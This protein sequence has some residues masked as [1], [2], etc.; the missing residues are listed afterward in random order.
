[1]SQKK[2]A[3]LAASFIFVVMFVLAGSP[4]STHAQGVTATLSGRILDASGGSVAKAA[5]T[6]VNTATGFTRTV[7]SSDAGEYFIPALPAGDYS[8]SVEFTGFRKQAKN[9]TLQVGQTA[10]YTAFLFDQL[11]MRYRD[12][13]H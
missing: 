4:G 3:A 10:D 1:M 7:Q 12:R 2:L 6:I 11:G 8:V 5:V 13:S 9:I